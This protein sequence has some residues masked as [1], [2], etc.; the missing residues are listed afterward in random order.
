MNHRHSLLTSTENVTY[1]PA[2]ER[3][4]TRTC[5]CLRQVYSQSPLLLVFF[6]SLNVR[7]YLPLI[8]LLPC[9]STLQFRPRN[10][11]LLYI[12]GEPYTPAI[13]F[14]PSAQPRGLFGRYLF[15]SFFHTINVWV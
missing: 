10:P 11:P 15:L 4:D 8:L 1:L 7:A 2:R 13:I 5:P 6:I 14:I 9:T 3:H 12:P